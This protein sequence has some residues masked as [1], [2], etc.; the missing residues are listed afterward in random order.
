M[1]G[2]VEVVGGVLLVPTG[3]VSYGV[4]TVAGVAMTVAGFEAFTQG[5]DMLRTPE[6]SSHSTGWLGDS[7]KA[8]STHFGYIPDDN[9]ASFDK[10]WGFAMLGLSLGGAGVITTLPKAARVSLGVSRST[11]STTIS[12]RTLTQARMTL[13]GIKDAMF[14]KF[15]VSFVTLPSA[16]TVFNVAGVGRFV[17]PV[18]ESLPRLRLRFIADEFAEVQER[19]R[20]LAHGEA[21][22]V[23][24]RGG[25][26]TQTDATRLVE[27]AAAAMGVS[28][29]RLWQEYIS[30]VELGPIGS[31]S[32]F[33]GRLIIKIR[34]DIGA[35]LNGIGEY[36]EF[37]A[38]TE[39]MHEIYHAM[40]YRQHIKTGGDPR[41]YWHEQLS[42]KYW[43]EEALVES[44]AQEYMRM[45][46]EPRVQQMHRYGN[47]EKARELEQMLE[48]A[49]KE[50]DEYIAYAKRQSGQ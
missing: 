14:G 22:L 23:S 9:Y 36:N 40:R 28:S 27:E 8:M 50:S 30:S 4:G 26:N 25:V 18:W 41:Q 19:A 7:V 16:R 5:L 42:P 29:K 24:I 34:Q 37:R 38:L 33:N 43:Q 10:Y 46:A 11:F 17:A 44:S 3:A 12:N 35:P 20:K 2:A 15:K 48:D 31:R 1:L 39:A 49:I 32:S 21:G 13:T 45:I 6:E 47:L